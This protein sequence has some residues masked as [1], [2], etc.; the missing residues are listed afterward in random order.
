MDLTIGV[1]PPPESACIQPGLTI[2]TDPPNDELDMVAA[3]DVQSL[4]ISEPFAFAPNQVV[5]TLKM[6][7][8]ATV[9]PNTRWPVTFNA[10]NGTPLTT[11]CG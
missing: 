4:Q 7:S 2:L 5:F 1:T 11:Q 6:Q 10:P 8:L 3:H 9:P